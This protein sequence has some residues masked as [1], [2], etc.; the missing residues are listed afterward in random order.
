MIPVSQPKLSRREIDYVM[1]AVQSGWVSSLGAYIDIFEHKF[2]EFCGTRYAVSVCNGTVGLHLALEVLGIGEGDEV[3][4]PDLTFVATANAVRMA[5]GVPVMVDVRRDTYCIDPEQIVRAI[6]PRTRAI[7]PVH[8]YGHPANMP[9]IMQ[10]AR[11]HNLRVIEDAA[12]AHGAAIGGTRVGAFGDCGV[13]SFYGNKIITSGEGGMITTNDADFYARARLLRDHAMSKE[14]RYWHTELGYNYRIT[15]L[16]AAL[17]A[18][19]LE[20]IG[21]F[22][23]FR[24]NLLARYREMLAPHGIECNPGVAADPVNWM[25][26]AVVEGLDRNRRDGIIAAMRGRGVE[27]RPFFFPMS[28]LP[29]YERRDNPVSYQLSE[30]GFNLPTFVGMTDEQVSIACDAFLSA[31][32]KAPQEA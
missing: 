30:C 20:Q 10:I 8:L 7:I 17:G 19:Q 4:V 9:L 28:M 13:F 14:I 1:D 21:E 27:A 23:A 29:M 22:L 31:L 16:Q 26:C 12:E 2:A 25:V 11:E 6:T 18:A 24:K 5:R 15:N 3:I 32:G